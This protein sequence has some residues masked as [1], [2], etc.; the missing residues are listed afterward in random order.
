MRYILFFLLF[1]FGTHIN[2]QVKDYIKGK[3]V[4]DQK[5]P[6]PFTSIVIS[7]NSKQIT[8]TVAD[9]NGN[10]ILSI[11]DTLKNFTLSFSFV[12]MERKDIFITRKT[13]KQ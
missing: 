4:D 3:I 11:P 12:G 7:Q 1:L 5:N 8:G 10:Y 9:I 2:A 6:V 13:K